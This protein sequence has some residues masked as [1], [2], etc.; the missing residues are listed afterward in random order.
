MVS[1]GVFVDG[2]L[3]DFFPTWNLSLKRPSTS[4]YREN[5]NTLN[6]VQGLV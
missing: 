1:V 4:S 2:F 6:A 5:Q 3:L